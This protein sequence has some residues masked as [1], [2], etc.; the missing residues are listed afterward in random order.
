[1]RIA[2]IRLGGKRLT[3]LLNRL[4]KFSLRLKSIGKIEARRNKIRVRGERHF[5]ICLLI[6]RP[7]HHIR[8]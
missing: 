3:V 5:A 8:P 2:I 7:A 4:V 1:M 6:L